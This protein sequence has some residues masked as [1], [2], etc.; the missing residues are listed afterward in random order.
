MPFLIAI[1]GLLGAAAFWWYR[2]KA[3]ND[4]AREVADVV[5]RVQGNIRRK[6][7]R[8]QAA[9]SPLTAIDDPVVAAAT[10]ITA[11]IAEQGPILPQR[12]GVIREVIAEIAQSQKKTDEAVV[13]AKWAAAQVDDTT[14]VIDKLAPFLRERL[15][16]NERNDLLQMLNRVAQGG[17]Q[18]LRIGDQRMLRLRQKLGFEVN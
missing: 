10:L 16:P 7:L 13:Y 9:L 8:K 4:A 5:G 3:M 14:I 12:E 15:D 11:I 18:S 2:L 6:K 17:E 1:L